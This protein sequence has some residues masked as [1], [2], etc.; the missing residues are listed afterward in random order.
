M[1]TLTIASLVAGQREE[2]LGRSIELSPEDR[3]F[4]TVLQLG[5]HGGKDSSAGELVTVH[6]RSE[7]ASFEGPNALGVPNGIARMEFGHGG[8]R[9]GL[10][11]VDWDEGTQVTVP[12]SSL[13]VSAAYPSD[14]VA[15]DRIRCSAFVVRGARTAGPGPRR[16]LTSQALN[17]A[18]VRIPFSAKAL[19]VWDLLTPS[20]L[21]WLDHAGSALGFFV[22][23]LGKPSPV[24]VPPGARD[25]LLLGP[26][27]ARLVFDIEG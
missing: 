25:V 14:V 20:S 1:Q 17:S 16:T 21:V 24:P 8:D 19:T 23:A 10:I 27:L 12:A 3:E 15:L 4:R 5:E 18:A 7:R 6:L 2:N 22:T 9:S 11:E 13:R 26:H